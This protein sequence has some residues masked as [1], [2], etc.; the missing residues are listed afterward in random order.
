MKQL[1]RIVCAVVLSATCGLAIA[2]APPPP[3]QIMAEND[4]DKNGEITKAEADASGT[5]LKDFF[6]QIDANKDGK[7]TM[8]ELKAMGG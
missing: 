5:P 4:T 8:A 7:I 3:E 2:Q 1:G 6:D